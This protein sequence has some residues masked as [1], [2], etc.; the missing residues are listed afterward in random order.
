M[1]GT[2]VRGPQMDPQ[3]QMDVQRIEARAAWQ[4]AE[5]QAAW[6]PPRRTRARR[7]SVGM[8]ALAGLRSRWMQAQHRSSTLVR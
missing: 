4:H 2:S 5:R 3:M 7:R 8:L 1:L 6:L